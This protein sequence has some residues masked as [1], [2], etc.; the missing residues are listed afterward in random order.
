MTGGTETSKGAELGGSMGLSVLVSGK[1]R[2]FPKMKVPLDTQPTLF[3]GPFRC[4]QVF[5]DAQDLRPDGRTEWD[6]PPATGVCRGEFLRPAI[7]RLGPRTT[8]VH[9]TVPKSPVVSTV[10][11]EVPTVCPDPKGPDGGRTSEYIYFLLHCREGT[12]WEEGLHGSHIYV[13]EHTSG[14]LGSEWF[15]QNWLCPGS[16]A[17]RL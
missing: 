14:D 1:S 3:M 4:L 11:V 9:S 10:G 5:R 12:G 16:W 6:L 8:G 7:G 15:S 2:K 17:S 13:I